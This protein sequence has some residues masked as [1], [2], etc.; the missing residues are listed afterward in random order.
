MKHEILLSAPE[1][2][3]GF[4]IYSETIKNKSAN[5]VN[6]YYTD[7]RTFFRY[8]LMIRGLSP[9]GVDFKE[10]DLENYIHN[11]IIT[12][13]KHKS[14][15]IINLVNTFIKKFQFE[16]REN[17]KLYLGGKNGTSEGITSQ[18]RP[19]VGKFGE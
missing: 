11:I 2:I 1:I 3:K 5:S 16:I 19:W 9:I 10:I 8:I 14:S 17:K 7:L 6:E 12:Y 4:L 18:Q 13:N 15:P